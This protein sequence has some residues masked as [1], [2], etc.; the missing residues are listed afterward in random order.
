MIIT[1]SQEVVIEKK[2]LYDLSLIF[3]SNS[4][5]RWQ[6]VTTVDSMLENQKASI[7]SNEKSS[8]GNGFLANSRLEYNFIFDEIYS[9]NN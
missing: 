3:H 2:K 8:Y 6:D 7:L 9:T 1:I 4:C 5:H